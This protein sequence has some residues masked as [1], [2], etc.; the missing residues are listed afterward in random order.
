M[1]EEFSWEQ[2]RKN[3]RLAFEQDCRA[4][5]FLNNL[6]NRIPKHVHDMWTQDTMNLYRDVMTL[7]IKYLYEIGGEGLSK[8]DWCAVLDADTGKINDDTVITYNLLDKLSPRNDYQKRVGA[9]CVWIMT[10]IWILETHRDTYIQ[11]WV[12]EE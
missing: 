4:A 8:E 2:E 1:I 7:R 3:R 5:I 6:Y 11:T 12:M 10:M 9:M